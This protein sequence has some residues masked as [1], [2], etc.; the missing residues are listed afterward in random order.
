MEGDDR[1]IV[2]RIPDEDVNR[3]CELA[4][5]TGKDVREHIR[6]AIQ[7]YLENSKIKNSK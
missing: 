7:Q 6:I 3:L 5:N 4:K 1:T 2:L